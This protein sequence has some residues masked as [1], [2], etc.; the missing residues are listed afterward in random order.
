MKA[1]GLL[2]MTSDFI[3]E[4]APGACPLCKELNQSELFPVDTS[5]SKFSIVKCRECGL[6]RTFPLPTNDILTTETS[7][8]YGNSENKF[9]P[10]LQ[11][12]RDALMDHRAHYY[13][14]FRY[15]EKKIPK[16][17][18]IGCAEGRLL[19][20]FHEIGCQCWG[21]EH[22]DYPKSRFLC[23][24]SITYI[25]R[26]MELVDLPDKSFDLIF[27]WHVLEHMD[28]PDVV[29]RKAANLLAEGGALVLAVPNF[30]SLEAEI[31][32]QSWFHLDVPWHKYHFTK[33]ALK[34]LVKKN[35][36]Q[37]VTISTFCLEQGLYGFIQSILNAMGWT[38]NE[39][40][41][42]L[43][44]NVSRRRIFPLAIQCLFSVFFLMPSLAFLFFTA[45]LKKGPVIK[46]VLKKDQ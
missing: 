40:Y 38:K 17:L 27:L 33:K 26:D 18:D 24:E 43:K 46:L 19:K 15:R 42:A 7:K 21:I 8:Y 22:K 5:F 37:I 28:N 10:L 29:I 12:I 16:V 6:T 25:Q 13:L 20:A 36:L 2:R 14:A 3:T 23:S 1:V 30:S 35:D 34:Y 45:A 39:L 41:E 44:G 11:K 32:K 31:F 9:L 4:I